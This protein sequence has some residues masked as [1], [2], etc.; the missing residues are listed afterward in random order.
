MFDSKFVY[1]NNVIE[2]INEQGGAIRLVK[3]SDRWLTDKKGKKYTWV[4]AGGEEDYAL[5]VTGSPEL[6]R[7]LAQAPTEQ[8][9]D[10]GIEGDGFTVSVGSSTVTGGGAASSS[11]PSAGRS[12][13]TQPQHD[14]VFTAMQEALA[15]AHDLMSWYEDTYDEEMTDLAQR[16]ATSFVIE[17]RR[18][19]VPIQS[20]EAQPAPPEMEEKIA[21][22]Y[23][24]VRP[25]LT[26]AEDSEIRESVSGGVTIGRARKIIEFLESKQE[27]VDQAGPLG[28]DNLPF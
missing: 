15:A 18:T 19:G 16:L 13:S 17:S 21:Q 11:S 10:L 24:D 1:P 5:Y 6:E 23:A 28:G 2:A 8:P 9:F 22:I 7:A 26:D 25:A 12:S 14:D 3:Q 27:Q 4:D 20:V